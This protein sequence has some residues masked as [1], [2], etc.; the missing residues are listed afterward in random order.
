MLGS[1]LQWAAFSVRD[2][3]TKRRG[4]GLIGGSLAMAIIA[5][6]AAMLIQ[7]AVSRS[8]EYLADETGGRICQNPLA[9]ANALRKLEMG[10]Q[11][12]PMDDARPATAHLFIANPLTGK[13]LL[14]LFSTHPPM[15]ERIAR[16][17]ELAR[18]GGAPVSR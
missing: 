2:A 16:L 17:E 8:R 15:E 9:L 10:V 12:M 3:M 13:G 18:G 11:A 5:P 1:M 4:G 14:Q 7:M 6:I